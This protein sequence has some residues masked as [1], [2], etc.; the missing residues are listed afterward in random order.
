MLQLN[1]TKT[2]ALL[3]ICKIWRKFAIHKVE[4]KIRKTWI[5]YLF[6]NICI[7]ESHDGDFTPG[8]GQSKP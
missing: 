3:I 6:L 5:Y 4:I 8:N 7:A 1:T 2:C